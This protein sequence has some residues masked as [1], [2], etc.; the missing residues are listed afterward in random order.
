MPVS[1]QSESDFDLAQFPPYTDSSLHIL[2]HDLVS[3]IAPASTPRRMTK[4]E[5]QSLGVW[6]FPT[7]VRPLHDHRIQHGRVCEN[8]LIAKR[9]GRTRFSEGG[10]HDMFRNI[11]LGKALCDGFTQRWCGVCY[12]SCRKRDFHWKDAGIICDEMKGATLSKLKSPSSASSYDISPVRIP[13]PPIEDA[14]SRHDPWLVPDVLSFRSSPL[15]RSDDWHLL[16]WLVWTEAASVFG[17]RHSSALE[18][19]FAHEP[20]ATVVVLSTTLDDTS[21]EMYRELG[22]AVRVVKVGKAEMLERAWH[23]GRESERW[24]LDWDLFAPRPNLFVLP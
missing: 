7:G 4:N 5:D 1:P 18:T 3:S 6:L 19:I 14:G 21:F 11:V 9:F 10:A 23:V 20:K 12:P 2:S 13:P 16:H 17:E 22:Y 24:L 8:D 15:S